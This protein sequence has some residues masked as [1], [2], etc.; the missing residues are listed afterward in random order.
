MLEA[1]APR[2]KVISKWGTGVDSI[3]S[4]GAGRLGIRVFNTP[5]AFTDAVADS[6]LGYLL[7]WMAE[8]SAINW[9]FPFGEYI[10]I[11]AT[12][13]RELWVAGVP[14]MDSLSYVF[15]AYASFSM[16]LLALGR[17]RWQ[18]WGYHL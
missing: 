2:L 12:V 5:G 9:G 15:L 16:A 18:G 6:V 11:P 17:G 14:F 3:D 13:D 7:A 10:Y 1:C 8:F 4:E